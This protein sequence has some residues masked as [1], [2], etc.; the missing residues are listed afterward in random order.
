MVLCTGVGENT[1]NVWTRFFSS[2]TGFLPIDILFY[3]ENTLI[4]DFHVEIRCTVCFRL[5]SPIKTAPLTW[6]PPLLTVRLQLCRTIT[7]CHALLLCPTTT[8]PDY[9][10]CPTMNG[11]TMNCAPL[12]CGLCPTITVPHCELCPTMNCAPL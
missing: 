2:K 3:T 1:A 4:Q 11:P 5:H 7:V 8:M 6:G 10:L 9:E 12:H